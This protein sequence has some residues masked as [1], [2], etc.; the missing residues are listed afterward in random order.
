MRVSGKFLAFLGLGV[1]LIVGSAGCATLSRPQNSFPA[2]SEYR[3]IMERQKAEIAADE[4]AAQKIPELNAEGCE[5][6]GDRYLQ[7]GNVDLAFMQYHKSLELEPGQSRVRYKIGYLFL[8]KGLTKEA[9][10]EFQGILKADPQNAQAREGLGR[11]DF[12]EGQY[13]AAEKNLIEALELNGSLWQ[14]HNFLGILYDRQGQF[15]KA[16]GEYRAALSLHPN[17][18]LLFNNLGV[19][20]LMKGE[21]EKAAEAFTHGL[22]LEPSNRRIYNNLALALAKMERYPEAFEAFK[23]GGDEASAYYNLG[24]IYLWKGKQ[25]KALSALEKAIEIKPGFYVKAYE[26]VRK[27]RD[28]MVVS[29]TPQN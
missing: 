29:P 15:E 6:L 17:L 21:T 8:L 14:A 26:K 9:R 16:I 28:G 25:K 1:I 10:R 4:K 3:K 18:G 20:L 7:Q 5:R 13:G 24:C 23:R 11:V 27:A 2:A 22:K 19:S 12:R